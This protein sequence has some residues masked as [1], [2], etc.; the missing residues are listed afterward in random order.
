ATKY[1]NRSS[2]TVGMYLPTEKPEKTTVPETP[3]LAKM[4]GDYKGRES[5]SQGEAFDVSPDNIQERTKVLT[6]K[7]GTEVAL[8]PKKTRGNSVNLRLTLRYGSA[9]TLGDLV[10][11]TEFLPS[12]MLRGTSK[13]TR[14]ELQDA[15]DKQRASL[16]GSG[17]PGTITFSVETKRDNLPA[18]LELLQQVLREPT[19]PD[20]ELG[21][22]QR[23]Q[24]AGWEKQ[25]FDPQALAT[26]AVRRHISAWPKGDPRYVATIEEELE[27]TKQVTT[28]QLKTLHSK[29]LTPEYGQLAIV[30]DFDPEEIVP[31]CEKMLANWKSEQPYER[32][33]NKASTKPG[34][35]KEINT[36]DKKNAVYFSAM[37]FAMDDSDPDYPEMVLGD[38]LFGGGSLSSR[39]GNRVRQKEGLSYG[40]GC[41]FNASSL[42]ERAAFYIYAISNPDNVPK[43][44]TVIDE[45]LAKLLKDGPTEAEV[46]EAKTGYLQKQTVARSSDSSLARILSEN[47]Y[48]GRTMD[49]YTKL[50]ATIPTVTPEEIR[51]AFN[52]HIQPKKLYTVVAGDFEKTG[53]DSPQE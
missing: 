5:I 46:E 50:E 4:I 43:L 49:Y 24:V 39:L 47:L 23:S 11:A 18:V 1:L 21:I 28:D 8:L 17:S 14:Q 37:S 25:L 31:L 45:E 16:A 41:G 2:R 27:W 26:T 7:S 3:S 19:F 30:G 38:F 13:Y 36:P 53:E 48:I 10:K 52:A 40:V 44:K 35:S 33:T 15:L 29:F 32:M 9:E 42:D 6:L 34:G 22:I 12:M 51:K 20:E